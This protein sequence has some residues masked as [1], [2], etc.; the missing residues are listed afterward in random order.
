[1]IQTNSPFI[2]MLNTHYQNVA[3]APFGEEEVGG[4]RRGVFMFTNNYRT[5]ERIA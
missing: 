2:I 5:L 3:V 1:M 4:T